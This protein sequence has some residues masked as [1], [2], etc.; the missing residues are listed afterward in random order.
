MALPW[1]S[2]TSA[3]VYILVRV[4]GGICLRSGGYELKEVFGSDPFDSPARPVAAARSIAG[5]PALEQGA[6]RLS[7]KSF[8]PPARRK[9]RSF[10]NAGIDPTLHSST[11]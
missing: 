6:A 3:K 9:L 11:S 4:V 8:L 10:P 2:K 1:E 7:P 5:Q